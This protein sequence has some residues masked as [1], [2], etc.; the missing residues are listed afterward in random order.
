M[1]AVQ[2][3]TGPGGWPMSVWLTPDREPFFGGTYF[4]PRDGARGARHGFLTVLRELRTHLRRGRG[5]RGSARPRRWSSAVKQQMEAGGGAAP[6]RRA[7]T[8][9]P[10]ERRRRHLQ[11][12]LRSDARRP[13]PRAQVPLQHARCACCCAT[14]RAP[15]T[16]RRCTWR[17]LT[18]EKMAAGGMYDQI[19]GGFH[20]YSTDARWLVPHFE[21]MLYDNALLAVAYAE[22]YQVTGRPDF[23]RVP[24]ETLDY[25]LRE[26]TAP[27]G[28]FYSATDADSRGRGGQVLRLVGGGDPGAAGR[29]RA[30]RGSCAT[31]TSPPGAT[32]R[33]TTSCTSAQ[34]DEAEHAA[35]APPRGRRCTRCARARSPPLRDD[36]ILAAWNGLMI[37]GFA[38]GGRVLGEPRYVDAAARAADF[39]LDT[40]APGR[41]P[42]RAAIEGRSQRRS[43]GFLEDQAF[44]CRACSI[45]SRATSDRR[46]LAARRSRWPTHRSATSP[47]PSGAAG[48]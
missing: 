7:R 35:L 17:R 46:W 29:R 26:M 15:A 47:T 12:P 3:L 42:A 13:A 44:V 34:P 41:P 16:P 2:A 36:K 11:A 45:C 10:I 28:G 19:G 39:L 37:S 24:R 4:P 38:V 27:E 21:K 33:A 30:P 18:L 31:T 43:P 1:S 32:S 40:H 48:S 5:A 20:R 14:T 6:R 22:A 8:R 23:A 25:V 9:R